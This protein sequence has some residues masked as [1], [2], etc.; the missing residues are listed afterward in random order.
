ME[1][2]M[3]AAERV[4][5]MLKARK[6]SGANTKVR[7]NLPV[8]AIRQQLNKILCSEGFARAERMSRFL[9]FIVEQTLKGAGAQ[10][11][12]YLVGVEVFDRGEAFDPRTDPVVRGEAR[13]LRVKLRDYYESEGRTDP[14][15]FALERELHSRFR[16]SSG[17]A[18]RTG[19]ASAAATLQ[20]HRRSSVRQ[21]EL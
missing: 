19:T 12:E 21:P 17:S 4:V 20:S 15:R 8:Q 9:R 14:I 1:A 2:E 6:S 18:R 5:P 13:R 7:P 11:K 3:G 16:N 10:L